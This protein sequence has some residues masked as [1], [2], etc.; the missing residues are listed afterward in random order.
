VDLSKWSMNTNQNTKQEIRETQR[1]LEAIRSHVDASNVSY[2]N[3]L[4]QRLDKLLIK[5]DMFWKQRAKTFWYRDGDLNTKFFHAATSTRRK[6]NRIEHLEDEHGFECRSE[7]GL[8]HIARDYFMHLFQKSPSTRA[9]VI[10][11]VPNSITGDDND[12]LTANFTLE[13]FKQA[14]FSMQADKC[15]GPDGFNPGFYQHFW[16]TCGHEVY[17]A[18]CHWL[19][20]V[21]SHLMS[22]LLILLLFQKA[23]LRLH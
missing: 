12:L 6:L 10:N 19:A 17:Q 14:A 9:S 15:L 21:L 20:A 23:I 3:M 22:I 2:F 5:D 7:D 16:D 1:K 11:L 13:E 18:G 8:K 4:R